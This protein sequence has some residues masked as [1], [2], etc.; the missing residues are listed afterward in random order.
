MEYLMTYGWSI[1]I[2][3]IVIIG[4]FSLGVFGGGGGVTTSCL[5][6]SG[7]V[8][9]GIVLHANTLSFGELGQNIGTNWIGVNILW[10]PQGWILQ[11][12]A[13]SYTWCP[14]FAMNTITGGISCYTDPNAGGGLAT[15]QAITAVISFSANVP[16]GNTQYSGAIWIEYQTVPGGA[17]YETQLA[18]VALERST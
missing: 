8:C 17:V 15:S 10:V 3:A 5:P 14:P 9:Q 18:K 4:L 7:Y 11:P 6:Q 1:L 2:I 13:G 16:V 12:N